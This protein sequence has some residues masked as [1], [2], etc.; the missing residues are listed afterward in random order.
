M[1]DK[2]GPVG[3]VGIVVM[4]AGIGLVASQNLLIAA[5]M[6]LIVGGLGVVVKALVSNVLSSFGM[7]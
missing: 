1:Y 5:G 7:M 2:L 6:A 3:I 4:L